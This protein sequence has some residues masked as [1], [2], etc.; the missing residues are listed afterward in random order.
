MNQCL[1]PAKVCTSVENNGFHK[2]RRKG[3]TT[4]KKLTVRYI[5][6]AL[7]LL[8]NVGFKLTLN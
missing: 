4:M 7:V 5:R 3:D 2:F 8:A 6:Y 1:P